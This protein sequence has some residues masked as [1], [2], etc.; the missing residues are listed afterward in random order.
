MEAYSF[1]GE[2]IDVPSQTSFPEITG[3]LE[4]HVPSA[5]LTAFARLVID[6]AGVDEVE[7]AIDGMVGEPG[8]LMLA[9]IDQG[10]LVSLLGTPKKMR[11]YL[12]GNPLLAN[13]MYEQHRATGLY[14]PLRVA[15][16]EDAD[17]ACHFTY[18][19]PSALL[20]Q[21]GN[22]EIRTIARV[23]DQRMERLAD[24]LVR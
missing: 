22:D 8:F 18:D 19:R 5:D 16:Y 11:V 1:A 6:R 24:H 9:R 21:F 23:L 14:A 2:R 10:P 20:E 12:I 15:I 13:R 3:A 4:T 17:G 7:R